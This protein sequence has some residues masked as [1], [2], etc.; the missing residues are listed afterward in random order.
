MPLPHPCVVPFWKLSHWFGSIANIEVKRK[1]K[2][3]NIII[4]FILSAPKN[5]FIIKR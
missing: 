2:K 1:E 3:N 4:S 5:F